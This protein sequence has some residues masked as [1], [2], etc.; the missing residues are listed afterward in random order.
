M[1]TALP[2]EFKHGQVLLLD[3]EP[4]V[5]EELHVSETAPPQ[6]GGD[7]SAWKSATMEGDFEIQV[8][9]FVAPGETLLV[10]V[11]TRK[12]AGKAG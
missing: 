5:V 2:A 6:H 4:H 12:Y 10:D 8:P 7:D 11:K 3:G 9:L 1:Q